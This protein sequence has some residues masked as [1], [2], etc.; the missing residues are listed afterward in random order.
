MLS[1]RQQEQRDLRKQ[2][3]LDGALKV[4]KI[5]GIEKTTMD[6]IAIE[7]GFGKATLYYYFTSKDEVFIAIMENGWKKLWE[8][9]EVQIVEELGPRKK[10]MGI[11]RTMASIVQN[12]KIL[13]GFL[14]TAPNHIQDESKQIWKTYQERLYAI[15]KSII[16]E[17]IK[18][19]E[20]INLNPGMLMKAIGG[21]FH[22]LLIENE[23]DMNNKE[24]ELML[25]NFLRPS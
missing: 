7:S 14:F 3:I 6:E 19:K 13:Y 15:L 23:D 24:F 1:K 20:F 11:I 18:K 22:G 9:I 8:G 21:L 4:F 12:N 16:E 5:H 25:K 2:S 10:F 17:G